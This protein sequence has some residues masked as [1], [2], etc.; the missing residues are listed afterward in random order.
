MS[1]ALTDRVRLRLRVEM[2]K[3]ELNTTD[4]AAKAGVSDMWLSRRL[5]GKTEMH[6]GDLERL[7]LALGVDPDE[8]LEPVA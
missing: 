3:R 6:L 1:D 8:L 7:A 5:R 4:L 2:A